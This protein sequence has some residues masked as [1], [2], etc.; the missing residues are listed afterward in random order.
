MFLFDFTDDRIFSDGF[1]S[2]SENVNI[3]IDLKFDPQLA[4]PISTAYGGLQ[5]EETSHVNEH[6]GAFNELIP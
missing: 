5:P 3:S 1:T 2:L 4:N 6:G